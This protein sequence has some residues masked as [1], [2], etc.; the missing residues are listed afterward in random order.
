[1]LLS[2]SGSYCKNIPC[3]QLACTIKKFTILQEDCLFLLMFL[4]TVYLYVSKDAALNYKIGSLFLCTRL[5][6]FSNLVIMTV[7]GISCKSDICLA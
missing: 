1:M 3:T 5:V 6:K 4:F 2:C 7:T